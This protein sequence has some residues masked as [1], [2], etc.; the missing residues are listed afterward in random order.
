MIEK[1]NNVFF[2]RKQAYRRVFNPDSPDVQIVLADLQKVCRGRG[3][4]YMGDVYQTHIMIGQNNIWERI[5]SYINIPD[6]TLAKL[7]E[8]DTDE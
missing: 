4:K 5:Q 2:K 8:H 3:T 6:S 1:F 7:T